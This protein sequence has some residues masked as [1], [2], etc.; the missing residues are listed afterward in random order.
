MPRPSLIFRRWLALTLLNVCLV[1]E[2]QITSTL[3]VASFASPNV[4]ASSLCEQSLRTAVNRLP[5]LAGRTLHIHDG[6]EC[7]AVA[8]RAFQLQMQPVVCITAFVAKQVG[9]A[10][11]GFDQNVEIAIAIVVGVS[12]ASVPPPAG[13]DRVRQNSKR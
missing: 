6:P 8:L 4:R 3:A 9:R 5:L 13:R 12:S 7:T 11:I 1:P 10:M 2:G